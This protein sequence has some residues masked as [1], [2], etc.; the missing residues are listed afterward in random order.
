MTLSASNAETLAAHQKL[1]RAHELER[2]AQTLP[3]PT[4]DKDVKLRLREMGHPI[5]LFGEGPGDRRER[6][7]ARVIEYY[8]EHDGNAPTFCLR[9]TTSAQ[10]EVRKAKDEEVFYTEGSDDLKNAR[11]LI[12]KY[13]LPRAQ[14]RL[15]LAHTKRSQV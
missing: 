7:R 12:A 14:Q 4:N 15:D 1:Q 11:L 13:S 9:T 10:Q 6:L 8:I 3:I 2:K 5:C